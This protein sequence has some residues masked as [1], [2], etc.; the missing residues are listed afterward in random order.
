MADR[1]CDIKRKFDVAVDLG[2]GRGYI[3]PHVTQDTIGK[4]YQCEL[5]E[6]LLVRKFNFQSSFQWQG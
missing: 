3:S 4:L 5:A 6:K 2:A 1:L